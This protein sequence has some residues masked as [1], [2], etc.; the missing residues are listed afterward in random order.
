MPFTRMWFEGNSGCGKSRPDR[1]QGGS[2]L[3]PGSACRRR[4]DSA[5]AAEGEAR[6]RCIQRLRPGFQGRIADADEFYDRITP[7]SLNEDERRVH[8]Q[9]LAGMLWSK[10]FYYF[11][12]ER[13]L[14][15][16]K[17]IRC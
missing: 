4:I 1:D 5:P 8:R 15:E 7:Q 14:T 12:L 9:A 6:R 16:H 11:D 17:A 13:W 2:P 10:Q 3:H